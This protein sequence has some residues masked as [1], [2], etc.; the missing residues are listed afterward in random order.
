MTQQ[1]MPDC[2]VDGLTIGQ[3]LR[4]TAQKYADQDALVFPGLG[5][6]YTYREFDEEVDRIAKALI[7]SGVK[8]GDHVGCWAT[9]VPEWPVLQMATAR[10]GAVLVTINPAYRSSELSYVLKQGDITALFLVDQFKKSDYHAILAEAVPSL[11]NAK[12]GAL[13]ATDFPHLKLVVNLRGETPSTMLDYLSF[14]AR[15]E[16][17]SDA[18]C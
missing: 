2:W 4:E 18:C 5:A 12:D 11:R 17:T 8:K 1:K 9:N 13:D 15:A 3:V 7:A 14:A 16:A 6:R 10:M